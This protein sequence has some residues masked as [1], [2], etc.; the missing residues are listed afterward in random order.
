MKIREGTPITDGDEADFPSPRKQGGGKIKN[1]EE[2]KERRYYEVLPYFTFDEAQGCAID[3]EDWKHPK[4][5]K[6]RQNEKKIFR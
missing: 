4:I 2:Y 3:S 5:D 1:D 6:I